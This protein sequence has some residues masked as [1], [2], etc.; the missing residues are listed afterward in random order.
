M[1]LPIDERTGIHPQDDSFLDKPR[2]ECADI[3]P[4][5]HPLLLYYHPLTLSAELVLMLEAAQ[6][7]GRYREVS[8]A[9][10]RGAKEHHVLGALG[11]ADRASAQLERGANESD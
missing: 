9:N 8:F 5:K 1:Y 2:W 4:D 10:A 11:V 6:R 7:Q 3:P